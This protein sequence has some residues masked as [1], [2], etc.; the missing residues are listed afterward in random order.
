[1]IVVRNVFQL[2]FGKAKEATTAFKDAM[3]IMKREGLPEGRLLMDV[4]G[5]F[6]TAVLEHTYDN[7]SGLEAV[8]AKIGKSD[9]WQSWYAK[10]T[11]LVESGHRE[12][13]RVVQ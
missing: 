11:P 10:F 4:T 12:V 6:Y 8:Q 7:L 13:F 2:K 9:A 5:S 1:M 3:A